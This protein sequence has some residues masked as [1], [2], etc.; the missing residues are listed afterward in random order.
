[1]IDTKGNV[2][3][4]FYNLPHSVFCLLSMCVRLYLRFI[5]TPQSNF[6]W[7]PEGHVAACISL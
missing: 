3:P 5:H 2:Q 1:M 6:I 7:I 4:A